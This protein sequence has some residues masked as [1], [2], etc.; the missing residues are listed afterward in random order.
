MG[1]PEAHIGTLVALARGVSHPLNKLRN[2]IAVRQ[3]S[4]CER[5]VYAAGQYSRG[6]G[7][8]AKLAESEKQGNITRK[9]AIALQTD[10]ILAGFVSSSLWIEVS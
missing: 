7:L 3:Y 8:I 6:D 2:L 1:F 5:R 10:L 4:R 9:E